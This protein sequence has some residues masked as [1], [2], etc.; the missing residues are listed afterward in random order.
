M[1]YRHWGYPEIEE[2]KEDP[3]F[4]KQVYKSQLGFGFGVGY[5]SHHFCFPRQ[6]CWPMQGCWPYH[7]CWPR[8]F[9]WPR[10]SCWPRE[11]CWPWRGCWP[12]QGCCPS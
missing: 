5:S 7:S 9:C 10:Q 12:R 6:G 1:D 11:N 3:E 4:R 2:W 8:R